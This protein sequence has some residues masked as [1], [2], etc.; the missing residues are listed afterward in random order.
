[1]SATVALA[2]AWQMPAAF[3]ERWKERLSSGLISVEQIFPANV[4]LAACLRFF[5]EEADAMPSGTAKCISIW[6]E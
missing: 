1:M 5:D 2:A 3:A 6:F 4:W